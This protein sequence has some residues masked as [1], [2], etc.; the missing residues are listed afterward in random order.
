MF[1]V[2]PCGPYHP[3]G[4]AVAPAASDVV[5]DPFPGGQGLC[6]GRPAG[7]AGKAGPLQ[8]LPVHRA[9]M[10]L[11]RPLEIGVEASRL[12]PPYSL[13]TGAHRK[14]TEQLPLSRS[15]SSSMTS[16]R[17]WRISV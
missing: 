4:E 11:G 14:V 10:A 9:E 1:S 8:V 5:S 3:W 15:S 17:G 6:L 2:G 13:V 16:M 7:E 12:V